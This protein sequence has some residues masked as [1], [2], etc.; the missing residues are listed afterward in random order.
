M[1]SDWEAGCTCSRCI[2]RYHWCWFLV[3]RLISWTT[4]SMWLHHHLVLYLLYPIINIYWS[5][6]LSYRFYIGH[7]GQVS[8]S[9]PGHSAQS[10]ET[11]AAKNGT[12]GSM[13]FPL[14]FG[15][16]W[17]MN[18]RILFAPLSF[19][20]FGTQNAH[21]LSFTKFLIFTENSRANVSSGGQDWPKSRTFGDPWLVH[22]P[23]LQ[24]SHPS[25]EAVFA[26]IVLLNAPL[27]GKGLYG[28]LQRASQWSHWGPIEAVV[29]GF[30]FQWDDHR[31]DPFRMELQELSNCNDHLVIPP[32]ILLSLLL[33]PSVGESGCFHVRNDA[34]AGL[35]WLQQ[36]WPTRYKSTPGYPRP[37]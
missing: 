26:F 37:W 33:A 15:R 16:I 30:L 9:R 6:L 35:R 12:F 36:I 19:N 8:F 21:C 14:L 23:S 20:L 10:F 34:H 27:E 17:R 28:N 2:A 4:T 22:L 11:G 18:L 29:K 25:F 31:C 24:V 1:V 5:G 13:T 32:V 7:I 3:L